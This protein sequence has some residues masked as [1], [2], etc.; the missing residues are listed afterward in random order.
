MR[1]YIERAALAALFCMMAAGGL[2]A[3][4]GGAVAVAPGPEYA[5]GPMHAFLLGEDY[6]ELWATPVRAPVLD[7][8]SYSGGLTP[9]RR[10]GGLQTLG[11]R[12]VDPRG[13]EYNFRSVNKE[14]TP[15]LPPDA[16]ET[17]IDWL[18]QDQ[19]SAQLPLAPL[20]VPVF[21]EAVGVLH[22]KPELY[23]MPDDPRLGEFRETFAGMMGTL[24]VHPE[25]AQDDCP[26]FAGAD[27]VDGTDDM[28]DDLEDHQSDRV[29]SR[30]FLTARLVDHL[31]GDWDRHGGNW[32]WARFDRGGVR[33]WVPIP[34]DR[35]YAFVDYDG[36]LLT[37]A[38]AELNRLITWGD[39]YPD[40]FALM[41]NSLELNQRVLADLPRA[42]WDS[43]AASVQARITDAVIEDAVR[44]LPPEH[45]AL[46]AEE[47]TRSLKV[48]RDRM[49]EMATEFYLL[50][51]QEPEVHGTDEPDRLE[52][53][54]MPDGTLEVTIAPLAGGEPYFRR[55]FRP[56]ETS[57]VRIHLHGGDDHAVVRREGPVHV[58]VRVIGGGGDDVL[59]DRSRGGVAFYDHRGENRFVTG[60]GTRVDRRP[61][62]AEALERAQNERQIG[63]REKPEE[64]QDAPPGDANP[65]QLL[66]SR[67][68]NWG[69]NKSFFSPWAGWV[70]NVGPVVGVGPAVTRY[71][72]RRDP[73]HFRWDARL[74]WAPLDNRFGVHASGDLRLENSP[75]HVEFRAAATDV[76]VTRFHGFGNETPRV[77]DDRVKVWERRFS[78]EVLYSF[79]VG[80]G[81]ELGIGPAVRY[82]Q[83]EVGGTP[84]AGLEGRGSDPFGEAGALAELSW[85]RRDSPAYPRRG[86]A[87]EAEGAAFP[88]AWDGASAF[89]RMGAVARAYLTPGGTRSPTLAL[90]GGAMHAWGEF[91]F[92][93]AAYVGGSGTL[94]GYPHARF[95]GESALFGGAEARM[96]VTRT[97]L[98]VRG[99]LGVLALADAGRVFW[100]EEESD[101]WHSAFGGGVWFSFLA[102]R[103]TLSLTA[104][105]GEQ[106]SF[107]LDL[108]FPF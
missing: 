14:L 15:A 74:L 55:V 24:E 2:A 27:E 94:R 79:P 34:E 73:Y 28:L 108:G 59:E 72:F 30:A 19:T 25:E 53:V 102:Q 23:V 68:R 61:Y 69:V 42:A 12:L 54:R 51:A 1:E 45:H 92:Q 56:E 91:P 107:Y 90:R 82:V 97:E 22:V 8:G 76:S 17:F 63:G 81:A 39:H 84:A 10:G 7:L 29:D 75:S 6:R 31:V 26:A 85:D 43:V 47:L 3:Q 100:E 5:A 64:A 20:V 9:V 21:L 101:R 93:E 4:E 41:A 13:C 40:L 67:Q 44:R 105:R 70:S 83:P 65:D 60:P 96:P 106:T 78:A 16:R 50:L 99:T 86:F 77:D 57:E 103:Y 33:W 32:R 88:L 35:D 104:A 37:V 80:Q 89:G 66:P 87:L 36:A 98:L 48:R 11:L 52:A 62:R 38:R 71:G 58:G 46:V 18:R 49:R 95:M